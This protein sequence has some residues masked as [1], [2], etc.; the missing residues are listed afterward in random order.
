MSK[1][2]PENLDSTVS[3]IWKLHA[4]AGKTDLAA[5]DADRLLNTTDFREVNP[6][7]PGAARAELARLAHVLNFAA[8]L[9]HR[10]L[11][12]ALP[13]LL[14]ATRTVADH[15][16]VGPDRAE[17]LKRASEWDHGYRNEDG[18]R[19]QHAQLEAVRDIWKL[20]KR[21][22]MLFSNDE[23]MYAQL[24]SV[25]QK[26]ETILRQEQNKDE[27]ATLI[28]I[29]ES[30]ENTPEARSNAY[31]ELVKRYE[32]DTDMIMNI[33]KTMTSRVGVFSVLK[34]WFQLGHNRLQFLIN[35]SLMKRIFTN[36]NT[37]K[38]L[39]HWAKQR[40]QAA[41]AS[42]MQEIRSFITQSLLF[43]AS[44]IDTVHQLNE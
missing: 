1:A 8:A 27:R 22:A 41:F 17:V 3:D 20:T 5:R 14:K 30:E 38:R 13:Y 4:E 36:R 32:R 43:I 40:E 44:D 25:H 29:V 7:N 6:E 21:L 34:I 31:K 16:P 42:G 9:D 19:E 10:E 12:A 39:K 28:S 33:T 24:N 11:S 37:E 35:P 18:E 2:L 26:L 15:Y 23:E